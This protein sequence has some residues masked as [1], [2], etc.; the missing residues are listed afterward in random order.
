VGAA[1]IIVPAD[2]VEGFANAIV[3]LLSDDDRRRAM[4]AEALKITV[5]Y[6][7]WGHMATKLMSDLGVSAKGEDGHA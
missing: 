1:G 5:P 4:G 2:F 6:F 7:T 3:R